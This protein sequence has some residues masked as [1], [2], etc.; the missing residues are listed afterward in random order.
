MV[1]HC[2][3]TDHTGDACTIRVPVRLTACPRCKGTEFDQEE[4]PMGKIRRHG[5]ATNA[6]AVPSAHA[7]PVPSPPEPPATSSAPLADVPPAP[8]APPEE[9][10]V[11]EQGDPKPKRKTR[12]RA[13]AG[14]P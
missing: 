6:G 10:A 9:P 1:W 7:V 8:A 5:G 13:S 12:A 3:G 4:A 11:T 14:D 2:A